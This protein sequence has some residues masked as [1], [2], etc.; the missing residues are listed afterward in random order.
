AGARAALDLDA[1]AVGLDDAVADAHPET[2]TALLQ[3]RREEGVEDARLLRRGHA[4]AVVRHRHEKGVPLGLRL[5]PDL[6]TALAGL[7]G[8]SE[9]VDEELLDLGGVGQ[10]IEAVIREPKLESDAVLAPVDAREIGR[11]THTVAEIDERALRLLRVR[12]LEHALHDARRT[13]RVVED[14]V[15][16]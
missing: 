11:L 8:V 10:G 12:E 1:A 5:H 4:A 16:S 14:V 7:G 3:P 15:E 13:P 6:A 2:R 9:Q